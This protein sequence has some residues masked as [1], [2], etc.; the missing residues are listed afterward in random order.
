MVGKIIIAR[1]PPLDPE[2]M[3]LVK[4][5]G[6]EPN[7]VWVESQDFTD[8]MM[9]KCHMATSVTTLLLFVPFPSIAYIVGSIDE[10]SLSEAAF[11]LPGAS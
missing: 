2:N 1:I 9:Q 3:L 10:L 4:L 6:I 5:H 8:A 11:G 7:G